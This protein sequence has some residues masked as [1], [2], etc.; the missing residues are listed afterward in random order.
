MGSPRQAV[1]LRSGQRALVKMETIRGSDL[2][3]FVAAFAGT[4]NGTLMK[5]HPGRSVTGLPDAPG[6]LALPP[7][8][9]SRFRRTS[10]L[11]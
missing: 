10:R 7:P 2:L 4:E 1:E 5:P 8:S 9:A 6:K 3:S 11:E